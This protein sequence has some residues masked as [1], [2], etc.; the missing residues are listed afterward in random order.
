ME[1][2]MMS[3]Q[4]P[5]DFRRAQMKKQK[6]ANSEFVQI[7]E[8]I[9]KAVLYEDYLSQIEKSISNS[10]S[11]IDYQ[12]TKYCFKKIVK[13]LTEDESSLWYDH[14]E[15]LISEFQEIKEIYDAI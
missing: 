15:E 3:M 2:M 1:K 12:Y 6:S 5:P 11:S 8:S 13:R 7:K 10:K 14:V 9:D 4:Y